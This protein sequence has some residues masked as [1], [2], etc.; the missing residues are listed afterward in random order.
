MNEIVMRLGLESW[1]PLLGA[2][3]LPPLPALLVV[4]LGGLQWRRRRGLALLALGVAAL[5]LEAC[6]AV[7][8]PAKR[9]LLQTPPALE[10]ASLKA[11]A[12]ARTAIVVLGGG[13]EAFAP[14]Y[15]GASLSIYSLERLRYGLW[16]SRA[17]GLGVGFSGGVGHAGV[18]GEAEAVIAARLAAEEF[19]HPLRWVEDASR[20]TRENAARSVALLKP[21]GITTIVLVTHDWH[22]PRAQRAFEQA[23]AAAGMA[24]RVVPAPV[25]LAGDDSLALLRWLPSGG[26]FTLMRWVVRERIGLLMGS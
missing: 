4:V 18:Q 20:D 10:V 22:M 14:E 21:Q 3:L 24:L 25:G 6:T 1:K 15:G 19:R 12:P 8:E 13:R 16:L 26:G 11:L 9:W 7:A 5:W 17:S 23:G 2:L